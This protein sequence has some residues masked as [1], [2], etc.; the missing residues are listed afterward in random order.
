MSESVLDRRFPIGKFHFSGHLSEADIE[1]AI[2]DIEEFP[3]QLRAATAGMTD[4]QL[5]TPY[6][7]GGWTVRQVV[8]HVADSH[9][10]SYIRFKFAGTEDNP[11]ILP[12]PEAVW[13][14]LEDAKKLPAGVSLLILEGLHRRWAVFLRTLR[15]ADW[16]RTFRHPESGQVSLEKALALYAWHGKHHLGH[17]RIAAG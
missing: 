7:P 15:G 9:M 2:R 14:D 12:Y 10:H 5:D 16:Q 6:R 1:A 13:A 8:H 11:S 17:V 3:A 4:E